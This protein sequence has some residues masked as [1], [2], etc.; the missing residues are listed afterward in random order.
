MGA[1]LISLKINY[2]VLHLFIYMSSTFFISLTF[3]ILL[4]VSRLI[5]MR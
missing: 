4:V 1:K 2:S 3:E 5:V